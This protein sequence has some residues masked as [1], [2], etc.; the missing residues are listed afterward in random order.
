VSKLT[1]VG[2]TIF[3][4]DHTKCYVTGTCR[5]KRSKVKVD[6]KTSQCLV[7]KIRNY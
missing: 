7:Y 5:V 2:L 4:H 6:H 3:R 1:K